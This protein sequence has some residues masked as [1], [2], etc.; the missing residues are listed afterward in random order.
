MY[1]KRNE[2]PIVM[3]NDISP[4]E[5]HVRAMSVT[6]C[7]LLPMYNCATLCL[8]QIALEKIKL[9]GNYDFFLFAYLPLQCKLLNQTIYTINRGLLQTTKIAQRR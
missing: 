6:M 1:Y 5:S 8:T 4:C 2:P 9:A 7:F 3:C